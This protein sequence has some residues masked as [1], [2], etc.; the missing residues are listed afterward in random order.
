MD[1]S[2][3]IIIPSFNGETR[4]LKTLNALESQANYISEIIVVIDGSTDNTI[5]V[6]TSLNFKK[7]EVKFIEQENAGRAKTR[8]SG[9]E[10]AKGDVLIFL[11]DD[12]IAEPDLVQKH[13]LFHQI[14]ENSLCGGNQLENPAWA[15]TDFDR[16][17][18]ELRKNWNSH[19]TQLTELKQEN[20][21]LTAANFS[22]TKKNFFKIGG[23]EESLTDAEDIH[24]AFKAMDNNM[25]VFFDPEI[26]GWHNDFINLKE[27]IIRKREYVASHRKLRKM[28]VSNSWI[29]KRELKLNNI[30]SPIFSFFGKNHWIR[31]TESSLFRSLPDVFKYKIYDLT[32]TSL[33]SLY[34]G[35]E[36]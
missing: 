30:K 27:Y 32:I 23:F 12:M 8:N 31:F 24:L 9:A 18:C 36:L 15:K 11:D 4:I 28:G 1:N 14:N 3:S 16:Y 21:H 22:I 13:Q 2:T 26:I 33:G 29:K 17:R 6:L 5:N 20:I 25:R 34:T 7:P 10:I 35:R 19:F